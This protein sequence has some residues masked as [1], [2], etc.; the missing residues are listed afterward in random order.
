LAKEKAPSTFSVSTSPTN[1]AMARA[2]PACPLI[3]CSPA[4]T[5]TFPLAGKYGNRLK[6]GSPAVANGDDGIDR[7]G[8][9]YLQ[10]FLNRCNGCKIDFVNVHWYEGAHQI[11][12]LRALC[13]M[14]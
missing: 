2:V 13:R 5:H 9:R 3:A 11:D 7:V 14:R 4:E 6:F 10:T 8:L 12:Y 1:A